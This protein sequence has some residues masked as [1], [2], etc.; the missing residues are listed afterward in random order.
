MKTVVPILCASLIAITC[1]AEPAKILSSILLD[2]KIL[3]LSIENAT[4]EEL[5][6]ERFESLKQLGEIDI[7]DTR[8]FSNESG[9]HVISIELSESNATSIVCY[10]NSGNITP[11]VVFV[12]DVYFDAASREVYVTLL[13]TF[14]TAGTIA[15]FR[16][17]V[18]SKIDNIEQGFE[19]SDISKSSSGTT[20]EWDLLSEYQFDLGIESICGFDQIS[21]VQDNSDF[22][23]FMKKSG[24]SCV[25]L[26]LR[27][28]LSSE[29]W[30]S[31]EIVPL[32][33]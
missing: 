6:L 7:I 12:G 21:T 23:I 13:R 20:M 22:L 25:A 27:Y 32:G 19:A 24:G 9:T 26:K 8:S 11:P 30:G 1:S 14:S 18:S 15:I 2:S 5:S 29:L 33:L 16:S 3:L 17:K 28:G 4:P 10:A 31:F